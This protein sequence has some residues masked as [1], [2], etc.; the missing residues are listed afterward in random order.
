MVSATRAR[1]PCGFSGG[2]LVAASIAAVALFARPT[3]TIAADNVI[4][5]FTVDGD[6]FDLRYA[7]ATEER[8][9]PFEIAK[10]GPERVVAI[11]LIDRVPD[12]IGNTDIWRLVSDAQTGESPVKGVLLVIDPATNRLTQGQILARGMLDGLDE[13]SPIRLAFREQDGRAQGSAATT[14][15]I[16]PGSGLKVE[17]DVKFDVR[18]EAAPVLRRLFEGDAARSSEPGKV[19]SNFYAAVWKG[20]AKAVERFVTPD[21]WTHGA[22]LQPTDFQELRDQ[23]FVNGV[24]LSR[25]QRSIAQVYEYD[26]MAFAI[27]GPLPDQWGREGWG[28][29]VLRRKLGTW[30]I[31]P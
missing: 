23:L 8:S 4:G 27:V 7:Y 20:D 19:L 9:L 29:V 18:V 15:A 13:T 24:D 12:G 26:D 2:F 30:K 31:A 11:L 25:I 10:G 3:A 6:E 22:P 5:T 17:F 28:Y 21:Y 1:N 16:H 14:E